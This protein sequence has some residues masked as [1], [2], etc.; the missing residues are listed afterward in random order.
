[1]QLFV[2]K[3][4]RPCCLWVVHGQR[5]LENKQLYRASNCV[6]RNP[7]VGCGATYGLSGL[8]MWVE[9]VAMRPSIATDETMEGV[10]IAEYR[11][12]K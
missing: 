12:S 2:C 11:G 5:H 3:G 1:M 10:V 6:W 8:S 9:D 7:A 4:Q